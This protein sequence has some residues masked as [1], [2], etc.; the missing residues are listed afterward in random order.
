MNILAISGSLRAR[1]RNT[2]LLKAAGLTV[3]RELGELPFFN[4]DLDLD[5]PPA[6]GA[7]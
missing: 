6:P 1:S 2:A 3:Y 5:P 7:F 4:P